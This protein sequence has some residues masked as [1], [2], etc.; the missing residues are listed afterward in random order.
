[1]S[2]AENATDTPP[3]IVEAS[4][5]P[6]MDEIKEPAVAEWNE[7]AQEILKRWAQQI[8]FQYNNSGGNLRKFKEK[9]ERK[10]YPDSKHL[11]GGEMIEYVT[12]PLPPKLTVKSGEIKDDEVRRIGHGYLP[13]RHDSGEI[14]K[15]HSPQAPVRSAILEALSGNGKNEI[16]N[17]STLMKVPDNS[18]VALITNGSGEVHQGDG[19]AEVAIR[20]VRKTGLSKE[21]GYISVQPM[22]DIW[23]LKFTKSGI[24]DQMEELTGNVCSAEGCS[25]VSI[26][27]HALLSKDDVPELFNG[28]VVFPPDQT[29]GDYL[30][31]RRNPISSF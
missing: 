21:P 16:P 18:V 29:P 25:M 19:L 8:V 4:V 22:S 13:I 30:A 23:K 3:N 20:I 11:Y 12:F 6:Q 17:G 14:F 27:K 2:N 26:P 10:D 7:M 5:M 28:T 24:Q 9:L 31:P 15:R 1:M